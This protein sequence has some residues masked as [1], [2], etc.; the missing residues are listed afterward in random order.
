MAKQFPTYPHPS[1]GTP[2]R[3]TKAVARELAR[4]SRRFGYQ[5]VGRRDSGTEVSVRCRL[6][7]WTVTGFYG[8]YSSERTPA[9]GLD[10]A[11]VE[12]LMYECP[13]VTREKT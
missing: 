6:C 8:S 3:L 2:V 7:R 11:M 10:R 4:S 1:D 13:T 9:A 12:H 5:W